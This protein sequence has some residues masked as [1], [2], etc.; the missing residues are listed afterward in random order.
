M[1]MAV[2]EALRAWRCYL[3]RSSHPI[4][5]FTDHHSDSLQYIKVGPICQRGSVR[6]AE[7]TTRSRS[8][9][10]LGIRT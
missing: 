9:I 2:V 10:M 8:A 3:C 4:E 5:I 7:R 6:W 1:E